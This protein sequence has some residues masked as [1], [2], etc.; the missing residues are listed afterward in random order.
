MS[1]NYLKQR[2][3]LDISVWRVANWKGAVL[4][5]ALGTCVV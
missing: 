5:T 2:R 1:V 3:S 4:G